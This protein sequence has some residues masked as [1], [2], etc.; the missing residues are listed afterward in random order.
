MQGDET[1]MERKREVLL[2]AAE[3]TSFERLSVEAA[4]RFAKDAGPE[5][6]TVRIH[7]FEGQPFSVVRDPGGVMDWG[8]GGVGFQLEPGDLVTR[9]P[10]ERLRRRE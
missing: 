4:Q 6:L 2:R 10:Q 8:I 5:G 7:N 9:P 1:A 3:G